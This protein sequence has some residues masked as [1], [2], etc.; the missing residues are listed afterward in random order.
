MAG[1]TVLI[2]LTVFGLSSGLNIPTKLM[3]VLIFILKRSDV[4]LILYLDDILLI[5]R[6]QEEMKLARDTLIFLLQ[7]L[8]FLLS[9]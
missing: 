8:E 5:A 2:S 3:K 7:S 6:T 9:I 4:V 1:K